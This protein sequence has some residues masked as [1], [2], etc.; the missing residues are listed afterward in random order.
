MQAGPAGMATPM[1][2]RRSATR[3]LLGPLLAVLLA[4][5]AVG[6]GKSSSSSSASRSGPSSSA[7]GSSPGSGTSGACA[8][9]GSKHVPTARFVLHA[10]LAFGAFHHFI[11]TPYRAGQLSSG[12]P[13]RVISLAK[14]GAAALFTYHELK[15]A[16][17]DAEASPTLC[18]LVSPI[19]SLEN[20]LSSLGGQVGS[21]NLGAVSGANSSIGSIEQQSGTQVAPIQE[22]VPA[23]V[24]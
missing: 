18:H 10:G 9:V 4:L 12:A 7:A 8:A 11:Y 22:Q 16:K 24:G 19:N 23:S 21:G 1:L 20:R 5:A 13:H 6:C 14:A 17:S 15:V 3:F 2:P